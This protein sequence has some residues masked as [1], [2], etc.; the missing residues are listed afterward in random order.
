[1]SSHHITVEQ[2]VEILKQYPPRM[3]VAVPAPCNS[4]ELFEGTLDGPRFFDVVP[5]QDVRTGFNPLGVD[6]ADEEHWPVLL[7]RSNRGRIHWPAEADS[8]VDDIKSPMGQQPV[9][10][11]REAPTLSL[12]TDVAKFKAQTENC[13]ADQYSESRARLIEIREANERAARKWE[14]KLARQDAEKAQRDE[15]LAAL[16]KQTTASED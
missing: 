3:L 4:T 1:M 8:P 12:P 13:A 2:L 5:V 7:I 6:G 14:K 16:I 15:Y 10:P 11:K 9:R